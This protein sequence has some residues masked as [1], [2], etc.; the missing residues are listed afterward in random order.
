[1]ETRFL[2]SLFYHSFFQRLNKRSR[3]MTTAH[4]L[5]KSS[6]RV[7]VVRILGLMFAICLLG[8]ATT[9]AQR[10]PVHPLH[11][12]ILRP[13]AIGNARLMR[14]DAIVGYAQPTSIKTPTGSTISIVMGGEFSSAYQEKLAV[15]LQ[16]GHVY[17]LRV[18]DLPATPEVEVFPTIELIDRLYPPTGLKNKFPIPIEITREDILAASRGAF[19][20]R[21]VYIENPRDALPIQEKPGSSQAWFETPQG[22]DPLV[23]AR[24]L[25]RPV[26]ILRIGSRKPN[27]TRRT[28]T[29]YNYGSPEVILL[30]APQ[31][32]IPPTTILPGEAHEIPGWPSQRLW[33][34]PRKKAPLPK[35]LQPTPSQPADPFN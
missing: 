34:V 2:W 28:Q 19:I 4:H 12:G 35:T 1:M 8:S 13:G 25:G 26:A 31:I 30:S 11:A 9:F 5:K 10:G 15:G 14:G 23:A 27:P 3:T 6:K 20:T 17:R 7:Y 16:V 21:V 22:T 29:A 32:E 33:A 24:S 18:G